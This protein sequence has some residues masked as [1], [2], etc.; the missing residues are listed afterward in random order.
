MGAQK[1]SLYSMAPSMD[2]VELM[3]CDSFKGECCNF[4]S[5]SLL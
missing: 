5:L 2:C 1:G 4:A 3:P